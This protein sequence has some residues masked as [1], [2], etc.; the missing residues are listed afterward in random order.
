MAKLKNKHTLPTIATL[1]ISIDL[2]KLRES[3]DKL[4]SKFTDVESTNPGLCDNHAEL[5]K[6][7]YDNFEQINLTTS[8]VLHT[9]SIKER[10]RRR[11]EHLYKVMKIIQAVI[12]RKL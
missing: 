1:P 11:E 12:C 4:A 3:T 8:E 6:S 2:D 7:V 5:V 9:T 10:L